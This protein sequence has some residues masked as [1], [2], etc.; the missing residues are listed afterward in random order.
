MV[1]GWSTHEKLACSYCME[2]NKA[3]TLTIDS[4]TSFFFTI[5]DSSNQWIIGI[6][7]RGFFIGRVEKDVAPSH[8]SGEELYDVVSM[9]N[10]IVFGF[11]SDKQLVN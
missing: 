2:I 5:T 8:H 7:K 9:Y 1:F 10:N 6:K 11:Q 4:K 3:F